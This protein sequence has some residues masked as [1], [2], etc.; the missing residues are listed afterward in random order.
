MDLTVNFIAELL[1]PCTGSLSRGPGHNP[2]VLTMATHSAL[3]QHTS[4]LCRLSLRLSLRLRHDTQCSE[5]KESS[6]SSSQT[7]KQ[8]LAKTR[9]SFEPFKMSFSDIKARLGENLRMMH[10]T[11]YQFS[12]IGLKRFDLM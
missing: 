12:K 9:H 3:A 5:C 7:M 2:P 6:Q 1:L 8:H 10:L 4:D 11:C